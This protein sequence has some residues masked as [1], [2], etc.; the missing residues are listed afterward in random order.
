MRG[1][2]RTRSK[3]HDVAVGERA[4]RTT[5]MR[6]RSRQTSALAVAAITGLGLPLLVSTVGT[7][8]AAAASR[9]P[10][11]MHYDRSRAVAESVEKQME[12]K[13]FQ[14]KRAAYYDSRRAAGT[15]PLTVVQAAKARE[16]AV[17]AAGRLRR[18]GAQ[19]RTFAALTAAPAAPAWQ[20]ITPT[21][22]GQVGRTTGALEDVSGRVSAIAIDKSGRIFAGAAQGG[23]WRYDPQDG[24]WTSLTDNLSS[25]AVGSIAIAPSDDQ[26]I[27]LGA[28]EGDLSGDS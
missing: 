27:Y 13:G 8:S 7:T 25:L 10:T 11:V 2:G 20:S 26:T 23:V 5:H 22:T 9:K 28:G 12:R 19:A 14:A 18:S 17:K 15:K 24:T 1:S 21:D 6:F 3:F 4:R 16:A